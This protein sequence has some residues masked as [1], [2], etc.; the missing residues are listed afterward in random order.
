MV[1]V[2]LK[3]NFNHRFLWIL[4]EYNPGLKG[5]EIIVK[6]T[7]LQANWLHL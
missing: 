5:I 4:Y 7:K 1:R 2:N 3:L 6:F